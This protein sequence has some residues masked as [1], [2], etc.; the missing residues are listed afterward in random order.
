MKVWSRPRPGGRYY[1][2]FDTAARAKRL[3]EPIH[4]RPR[5]DASS[6]GRP[7]RG[8]RPREN[9]QQHVGPSNSI[10]LRIGVGNPG[11][12]CSD[13]RASRQEMP[14]DFT[15]HLPHRLIID[16]FWPIAEMKVFGIEG[17]ASA[18]P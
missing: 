15:K 5:R 6:R 2:A 13:I 18:T 12:G 16:L 10:S 4:S 8:L 14:F 17:I 3:R 1:G 9:I 7:R 11:R